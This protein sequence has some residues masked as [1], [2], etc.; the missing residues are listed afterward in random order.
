MTLGKQFLNVVCFQK[1]DDAACICDL[2]DK[3]WQRIGLIFM[4][5]GA[6]ADLSRG[7]IDIDIITFADIRDSF[8]TFE[9]RQANVDTVAKENACIRLGNDALR[10]GTLD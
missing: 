2:Q 1:V 5:A 10:P 9:N 7:E 3:G 4:S 8:R 6:V